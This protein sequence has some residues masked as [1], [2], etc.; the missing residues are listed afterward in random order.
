M[1]IMIID[2]TFHLRDHNLSN[3]PRM[4]VQSCL[5]YCGGLNPRKVP[6]WQNRVYLGHF[7]NRVYTAFE[8]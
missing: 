2:T 5:D 8:E 3:Y 4:Y 1:V 7:F 6:G